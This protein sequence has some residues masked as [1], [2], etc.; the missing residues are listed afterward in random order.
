MASLL[1]HGSIQKSLGSGVST[2]GVG[3]SSLESN[4]FKKK[5]AAV[6]GQ[7]IAEQGLR[8][9]TELL[10]SKKK[11]PSLL[12][13]NFNFLTIMETSN[14][15]RA[16]TSVSGD[17]FNK[18]RV[19]ESTRRLLTANRSIALP[20]TALTKALIT[21]CDVIHS[22]TVPGLGVRIDAVP[23]KVYAL[24]VPF[25][26]YGVFNGQCSEV[27]GLRHAYM[28]IAINF[29]TYSFFVKIVY[30]HFFASIDFFVSNYHSKSDSAPLRDG[31]SGVTDKARYVLRFI[32]WGIGP[33]Y[34]ASLREVPGSLLSVFWRHHLFD[35]VFS[36]DGIVVPTE[37]DFKAGPHSRHERMLDS[38][39]IDREKEIAGFGVP[40]ESP[41]S[42]YC[43]ESKFTNL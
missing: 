22:W 39:F 42:R 15:Y 4:V 41:G 7:E 10:K 29:V 35:S 27:C 37:I 17:L 2:R 31:L 3:L 8:V 1:E 38:R 12:D 21:G 34:E 14:T 26:Y 23:G 25:K 6:V 40:V 32:G 9:K 20:D 13:V 19:S 33:T 28:P 5:A 43:R 24:K 30:M 16:A 11:D 18:F 36:E